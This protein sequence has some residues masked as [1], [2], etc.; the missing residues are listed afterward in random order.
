VL[1]P[2]PERAKGK[3]VR[4]K[5]RVNFNSRSPKSARSKKLPAWQNLTFRS[6]AEV[7]IAKALDRANLLFFT[8][9][10]ARLDCGG[11]RYSDTETG[12]LVC[13]RI[14]SLP[15]A[16]VRWGILVVDNP[17]HDKLSL[18]I[19]EQEKEINYER[20]GVRVY[21]FSH[22]KCLGQADDVVR[23]FLLLLNLQC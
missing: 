1:Y 11:E 5:T 16:I 2:I 10:I 21:R 12:F 14:S 8:H 9:A 7:E 18:T 19:E 3:S 20:G 22:S 15:P 6:L 4:R 23:E 13:Y 17:T